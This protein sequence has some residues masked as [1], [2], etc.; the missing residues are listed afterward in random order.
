MEVLKD[1]AACHSG[2]NFPCLHMSPIVPQI[3]VFFVSFPFALEIQAD[4]QSIISSTLFKALLLQ[5][6]VQPGRH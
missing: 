2:L 4:N 6:S 1:A 3:F 5:G